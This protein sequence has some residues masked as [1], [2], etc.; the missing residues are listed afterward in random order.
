MPTYQKNI[1]ERM[2]INLY[3]HDDIEAA[4]GVIYDSPELY[5][6]MEAESLTARQMLSR[7]VGRNKA[8]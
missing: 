3:R 4:S 6:E 8:A 7:I 1:A 2:A 5:A